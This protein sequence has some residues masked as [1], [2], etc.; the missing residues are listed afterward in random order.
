MGGFLPIPFGPVSREKGRKP[1]R[2]RRRSPM[3]RLA[4]KLPSLAVGRDTRRT[5]TRHEYTHAH[6][7]VRCLPA[8]LPAPSFHR[9]GL[10]RFLI[11]R[12]PSFARAI[13][14]DGT[15]LSVS[16]TGRAHAFHFPRPE[17]N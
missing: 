1:E 2:T 13:F 6:A 4:Y 9:R 11:H 8:C 17:D 7:S 5:I 16:T 10:R 12:M 15:A 14:R 3:E